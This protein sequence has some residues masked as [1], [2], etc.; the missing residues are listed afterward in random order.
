MQN[1]EIQMAI[2][3]GNIIFIVIGEIEMIKAILFF[4]KKLARIKDW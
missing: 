4:L 2:K 3:P 1:K